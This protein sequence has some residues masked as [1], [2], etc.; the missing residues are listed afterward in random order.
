MGRRATASG[1]SLA[2]SG[3]NVVTGAPTRD[4]DTGAVYVFVRSGTTW[5]QQAELTAADG[6]SGAYFGLSVAISGTTAV[7]GAEG[8]NA[9]AGAAYVYVRSA[10]TK[11]WSQQTE[12]SGGAGGDYFGDWVAISGDIALIGANGINDYAGAAYVDVRTGTA[13]SQ[14]AVLTASDGQDDDSFGF[15][16]ALSGSTAIVSAYEHDAGQGSAYVFTQSGTTWSQSAELSAPKASRVDG[17]GPAVATS[18]ATQLIGGDAYN[19]DAGVVY[20]R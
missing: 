11:A 20:V 12:F 17:F 2:I 5:S 8:H 10:K 14:Q 18:A 4:S 16:L 9:N 1:S 6:A 15:S 7:V 13:W 19:A 3:P